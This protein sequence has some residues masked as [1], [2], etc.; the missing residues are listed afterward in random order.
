[1][2]VSGIGRFR[3]VACLGGKTDIAFARFHHSFSPGGM[4]RNSQVGPSRASVLPHAKQYPIIAPRNLTSAL[5]SRRRP[6]AFFVLVFALAVPISVLSRFVG[7][8]GSLKIPITDL[9]LAFTPMTAAS[10]LVFRDERASGLLVFLKGALDYRALWR[11]NWLLP[12]LMLAPL[13]YALTYMCLHLV[14][15]PG[16]P[17]ANPR[18]I[19]ALAAIM[20]L[21][22]IGEEVGWTGYL[23][24][25]LQSRFGALGASLIIAFPW[26]FAHIPSIIQIG[27][28]ASDIAWWFPGA[29]ALRVLMTWLYNNAGRSVVSVTL[30]HTVLNVGRS[31]SYPT[32]GSHYDPAYQATGN[33]IAFV[34]A[35]IVLII[36]GAKSVTGETLP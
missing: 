30:F 29:M 11:T 15:H 18:G 5:H 10:I 19:P 24:D 4:R 25:P 9:I 2:L 12:A 32:I 1:M 28:T 14:G 23:L 35:A 3:L 36:W 13:I 16:A 8:I 21:L 31:F 7:V 33:V 26:W 6:L 27:G 20:L 34:M 17:V 22:A